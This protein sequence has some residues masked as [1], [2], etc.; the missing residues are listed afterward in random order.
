MFK[1]L[2]KRKN[3]VNIIKE[4]GGIHLSRVCCLSSSSGTDS[5]N[6]RWCSC[7]A[8]GSLFKAASGPQS[9]AISFR[10]GCILAGPHYCALLAFYQPK[11]Q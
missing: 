10:L 6:V 4:C 5:G 2:C 7:L 3:Y 1:K 8:L 11:A 9:V